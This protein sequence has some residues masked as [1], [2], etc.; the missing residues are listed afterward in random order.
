M[1]SSYIII[2]LLMNVASI[3]YGNETTQYMKWD[4]AHTNIHVHISRMSTF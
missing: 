4:E 2:K 1:E 3:K